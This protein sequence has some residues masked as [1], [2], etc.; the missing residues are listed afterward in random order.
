MGSVVLQGKN[1]ASSDWLGD[2]SEEI[3]RILSQGSMTG[4]QEVYEPPRNCMVLCVGA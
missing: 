1:P 3:T 2:I 4:H